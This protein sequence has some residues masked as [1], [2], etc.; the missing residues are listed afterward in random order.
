M[1]AVTERS[2]AAEI[3]ATRVFDAPRRLLWRMW[4]DAEQI[5]KWWGPNGFTNT[6]HEMDVR[7]GGVWRFIMHG[8]D[9]KDY[10]NKIVYT[11]V[12]E[13]QRL[14]Y[15]HVSGPNFHA[16]VTFDEQGEKTSVTMRMQFESAE[17][18][19][20]VA[21]E[22]GAVEGLSQTLGR[23]GEALAGTVSDDFVISRDFDAPRDLVW[24]A[25]TE[26]EHLMQW[27]GPKEATVIACNVDLRP[28]G[29]MHFALRMPDGL[30]LWGKWTFREIVPPEKLVVVSSFSDPHG[31]LTR[32]PMSPD[33]PR[34][35]LSTFTFAE[36]DGQTTVTVRWSPMNAT[37]VERKTFDAGRASMQQ[38]WGGTFR[39]LVDYLATR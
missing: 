3:V 35:T 17:L 15:D 18:R 26:R 10:K 27:W 22:L 33:W 23:L 24:R 31:G 32:H 21:E 7:P 5:A 25:W 6:I 2:S 8:P 16:I 28:G 9:G 30:E 29:I 14:E 4:T 34:E 20:R 38:G 19:N 12:D 13:P 37:D 1:P 11:V 36:H 39:K